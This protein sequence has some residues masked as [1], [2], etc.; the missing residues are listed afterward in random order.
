MDSNSENEHILQA[1]VVN[2]NSGCRTGF[3]QRTLDDIC[4]KIT[5]SQT[6]LLSKFFSIKVFQNLYD[7]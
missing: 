7:I 3:E 5:T 6:D 2:E 1:S 4:G